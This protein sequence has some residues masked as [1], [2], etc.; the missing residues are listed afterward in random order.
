[1]EHTVQSADVAPTTAQAEAYEA[2]R[3]PMDDLI[4]QWNTLKATD[5]KALNEQRVKKGLAVAFAGHAHHRSRRG[6]PD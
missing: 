1:M 2:M 4:D 5:V 6:R 3:K